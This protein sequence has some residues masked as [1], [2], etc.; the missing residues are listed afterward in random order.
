M[1]S[2]QL[3]S[4][5]DIF[6]GK[7]LRIPDYQR[8]YAWSNHQLKDFWEDLENLE[9]EHIHYTGVL[10]FEKV[11]KDKKNEK[12][13]FWKTDSGAY[14]SDSAYYVVDGQQRITTSI[15]LLK[16]ILDKTI[17]LKANGLNNTK[18]EK[19]Y[20]KYIKE[21]TL[22]GTNQYFFGYTADN[23]SYEFLKTKIFGEKSASNE[24]KETLYTTNLENAKI[25][26]IDEIKDFDL[27]NIERLLKK[28]TEQLKF[29]V[30]EISDDLDVFVAFETMN[31]RGKKLSN[32]EL[33]KNRLI[34][35]ST[36]FIENSNDKEDLRRSINDCWKTIY[37]YL[38]KNKNN[39]LEDDTF[40][41]N[42]WIMYYDYSREKGNDYIVDLLEERYIAK[43]ISTKNME[44]SLSIKEIK[45]YV[46][47]L[48]ESVEHWYYLYN[49]SE[50]T[51]D[52]KIKILLDKLYR[53][54]Y[55]AFAPLLM[56]IF[57]RD[58]DYNIEDV[59]KLLK[60]ME[61]YIF[62][63]FKISQ[64]RANTGDSS[65]YGYARQYYKKEL[66]IAD[67]IGTEYKENDKYWYGITGWLTKYFKLKSFHEY[68][69][70]KFENRDGYFSGNGLSY[71]LFEYELYLKTETKNAT[72][73]INWKDY[74]ESKADQ[75]SIEH[76]LPQTPDEEC[77]QKEIIGLSE[78]KIKKLTNSL[79][80]LVPLSSAKNSK[81]QNYC[82]EI[83]KNGKAGVFTGYQNG[84]YAEQKINKNFNWGKDEIKER[85]MELLE[86][87][88]NHW[89]IEDLKN[90]DNRL[91]Y[92]FLE[93]IN[94]SK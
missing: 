16:V 18:L 83:K 19:L 13:E 11:T 38:G 24:K 21:E 40:L 15:I 91:K 58:S 76:I 39:I 31:N 60:L 79:G 27:E 70:D 50:A 63:I 37:E 43:R 3:E 12:I 84:S 52:D 89:D 61:R 9:D 74:T 62:L 33:L 73:K 47:S 41:K 64:R 92:L 49:P 54:N 17:E 80:N 55:G 25:F 57:S 67:M 82:F 28:L 46:L 81:L 23:P 36:K 90:E 93:S 4:L 77:W 66:S 87:M 2:N 48:K 34:Y 6:N 94:S 75:R 5:K 72:P 56:A 51:Y 71:F 30:Y 8:G 78:S 20:E 1:A 68:L 42:H 53:L 88:A 10:T 29:N 86:F 69:S 45:E 59:C 7:F 35:L 26:F 14:D 32:L 44:E 22:N 85:G 65:F